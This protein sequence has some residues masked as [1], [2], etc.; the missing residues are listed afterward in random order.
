MQ[1]RLINNI[2]MSMDSSR[3]CEK[4]LCMNSRIDICIYM[5]ICMSITIY[6]SLCD[7]SQAVE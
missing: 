2:K 1:I 3:L 6:V 5:T 7:L 4:L